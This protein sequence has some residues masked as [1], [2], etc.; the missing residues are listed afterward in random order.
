MSPF[1]NREPWNLIVGFGGV[2]FFALFVFAVIAALTSPWVFVI[3]LFLCAYFVAKA[4]LVRAV[5]LWRKGYFSGSR[6]G[7]VWVYE[8]RL[9][10]ET[11][12]LSLRVEN[13][14]PGHYELF[15]P[16]D[17][18]WR[19]SVPIWAQDRRKEIVQRISE[20]WKPVDFHL[21]ADIKL[22]ERV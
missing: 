9:G 6:K 11:Q 12:S 4:P 21:P 22:D 1:Y 13:T 14:E 7:N 20:R 10:K 15:V 16:N 18:A 2:L 17:T 5:H 19:A 3:P 8:E